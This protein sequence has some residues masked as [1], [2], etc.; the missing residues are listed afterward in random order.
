MRQHLLVFPQLVTVP[1]H[2]YITIFETFLVISS[3][4]V[5][6][7]ASLALRAGELDSRRMDDSAALPLAVNRAVLPLAVVADQLTNA[8]IILPSATGS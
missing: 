8:L 7:R 1:A 2:I 5:S 6:T 4:A 3:Q